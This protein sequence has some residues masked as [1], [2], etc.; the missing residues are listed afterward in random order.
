MSGQREEEKTLLMERSL[1]PWNVWNVYVTPV[2]LLALPALFTGVLYWAVAGALI[3]VWVLM[4]AI[5]IGAAAGRSWW[6][7]PDELCVRPVPRPLRPFFEVREDRRVPFGDIEKVEVLEGRSRELQ[8]QVFGSEKAALPELRASGEKF[9]T[10]GAV[11]V[12]LVQPDKYGQTVWLSTDR[13]RYAYAVLVQAINDE[14]E[15]RGTT[16]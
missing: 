11:I 14:Q 1:P 2:T 10:A 12:R 9:W 6:V 7:T 15:R 16:P 13:P 3:G 5:F 4:V 8:K